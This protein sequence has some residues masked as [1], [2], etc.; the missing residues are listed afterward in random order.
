[1]A[2]EQK[3]DETPAAFLQALGKSLS[4]K[5]GVD[6]DL[7]AILCEHILREAPAKDAVATAKAAIAKLAAN[8]AAPVKPAP[9]DG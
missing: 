5:A 2:G 3:K 9:A 1:M 8:R 6:A 7:A 4:E